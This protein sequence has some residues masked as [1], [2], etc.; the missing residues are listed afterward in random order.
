MT[1]F[2]QPINPMRIT[3][4]SDEWSFKTPVFALAVQDDKVTYL[5]INGNFYTLE[6][7]KFAEMNINGQWVALESHKH[8]SLTPPTSD[9]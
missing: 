9:T 6:K 3:T 8:P 1:E 5:T 2:M 7:I 4:G